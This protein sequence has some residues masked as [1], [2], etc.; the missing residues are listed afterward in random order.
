MD[1]RDQHGA[2]AG[3]VERLSVERERIVAIRRDFVVNLSHELRTPV[4]VIQANTETLLSGAVD[5]PAQARRF[6]D[7]VRRNAERLGQLIAVLLDISQIEAGQ[8]PIELRTVEM[9]ALAH[10]VSKSVGEDCRQR[11]VVL[12]IDVEDGLELCGD[13]GALEQ[14]LVHLV[15]NAVAYGPAGGRVELVARAQGSAVHIEVR[16][17]GPGIAPDARLRVFERFYRVDPGRSRQMGGAGLGLAIVKNLTEAMGGHVGVE[18][19]DP[20]GSVFW[21]RLA[22]A[23]G[24]RSALVSLEPRASVGPAHAAEID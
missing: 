10:A 19:R 13:A 12:D 21:V 1:Q 3:S 18:A 14:I 11:G 24:E 6:L 17:E 9:R 23:A 20:S 15:D 16:D 5:D 2:L 4:S 7:A 22:R 8:Y